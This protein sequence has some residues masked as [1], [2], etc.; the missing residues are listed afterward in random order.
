VRRGVL[1]AGGL[2]EQPVLN[3]LA[4][5]AVEN[6]CGDLAG[7]CGR[8]AQLVIRLLIGALKIERFHKFYKSNVNEKTYFKRTVNAIDQSKKYTSGFYMVNF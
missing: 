7:V 3:D 6:L 8:L 2:I 5:H 4:Q 1:L